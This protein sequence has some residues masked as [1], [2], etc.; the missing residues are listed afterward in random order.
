MLSF[1][2][3]RAHTVNNDRLPRV[4]VPRVEIRFLRTV[5]GENLNLIILS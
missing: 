1:C 4:P 5:V 3:A 2:Q